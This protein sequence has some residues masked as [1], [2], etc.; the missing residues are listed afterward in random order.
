MASRTA[1]TRWGSHS[2]A[3]SGSRNASAWISNDVAGRTSAVT[4]TVVIAGDRVDTGSF[5]MNLATITV[6]GKTQPQLATS[7][8]T[9]RN[10]TAPRGVAVRLGPVTRCQDHRG[11]RTWRTERAEE[12]R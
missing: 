9:P 11:T 5:G 1:A 4:G 8:N 12:G 3:G 7:L 2:A 6:G 10:A